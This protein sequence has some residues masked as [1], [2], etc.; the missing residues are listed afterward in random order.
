MT[1]P[2]ISE[3]QQT[4][5][6]FELIVEMALDA[7]LVADRD[8]R[9]TLVNRNAETLFGYSRAEL[10]G[11]PLEILVPE[12]FR[13]RHPDLIASF[14]AA[15]KARSM[16]GGRELFGL[17]KD[18]TEVPIEIG[19]NPIE[20]TS[21]LLTLASII[22]ITERKRA[23]TD[24][25]RRNAEFTAAQKLESV[26]RLAG[27]VAHEINTPVQFVSDNVQF[28]RTSMTEIITVIHA[29]RSLQ[30]AVQSSGDVAAAAHA[31]AAAETT[32]DLDFIVENA[33]LAIDSAIDGLGRIATIVRSMKEFA[34]PDQAEKTAADLNRAIQ[35]TLVVAHNEY[36]YVAEI[37]TEFGELPP[38]EC[39]LGEIN[40]VVLNLVINAAHAIADVVKDTANLGKLTVRTRLD[41][42]EVEI[43]IGDTGTGIPEAARDKI[44]DPFFTTKEVGKGTGQGLAIAYSV[45][46]KKHGGTLRFETECGKGTTFFIRL[47]IGAPAKD[48]GV[49]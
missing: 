35:S 7:I 33:S 45:I 19:L 46:V 34:H 31:A 32:A 25:R 15:P 26:G 16:G 42:E 14:F 40:Q 22:D 47:P 29:Y 10:L 43:A 13:D 36:K 23:E 44:F 8:R 4:G 39:Y 3:A 27:G 12:R 21:G 2:V 28:M 11:Q 20:T 17:R 18:G 49:D 9:I 48:L 24:L 30:H 6:W 38:V 5:N 37:N 1:S 41:G